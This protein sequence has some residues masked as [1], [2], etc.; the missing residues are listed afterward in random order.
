MRYAII[1]LLILSLCACSSYSYKWTKADKVGQVMVL[2]AMTMDWLQTKYIATHGNE[3][4]ETNPMLGDHPSKGQ[5]NAYFAG[6]AAFNV[7]MSALLPSK[8]VINDDIVFRPRLMW[9]TSTFL[10]HGW[11]VIS[12]YNLGVGME[13]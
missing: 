2:G 7:G 10:G 8:I 1:I 9:Q 11:A 3:Y 13:W 5:V 4:R 6:L 12:N